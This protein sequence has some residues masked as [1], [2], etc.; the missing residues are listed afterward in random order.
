[1]RGTTPQRVVPAHAEQELSDALRMLSFPLNGRIRRFGRGRV[2]PESP[3]CRSQP[4]S[5][6]VRQSCPPVGTILHRHC[7]SGC[8]PVAF[9]RS[10]QG[11]E[12]ARQAEAG[13][14]Q[15]CPPS[16]HRAP[17]SAPPRSRCRHACQVSL[18]RATERSTSSAGS[19][20]RCGSAAKRLAHGPYRP[21]GSSA[22]RLRSDCSRAVRTRNAH[23]S[24][25]TAHP[26]PS[27]ERSR[28]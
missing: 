28:G 7:T 26:S 21:F 14:T 27:A 1:M 5:G 13:S 12:V 24:A 18:L 11:R 6:R 3:R 20:V 4:L 2:R 25:E 22:S 16:L 23:A 15:S 8:R 10:G 17:P 9:G 19:S